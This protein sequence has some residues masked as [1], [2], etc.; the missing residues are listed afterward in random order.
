MNLE[1]TLANHALWLK[2]EGG[3]RANLW[4]TCLKGA[5]LSGASLQEANLWGANL[6]KVNLQEANLQGA[7]LQEANLQGA[8]LQEANL[9]EAN[10]RG[11]N[12]REANLRGANLLGT[13][14]DPANIPNMKGIDQFERVGDSY[15]GYRTRKSVFVGGTVYEDGESYTAPVFSTSETECHPG[16][17]LFPT[18]DALAEYMACND[19]IQYDP[20]RV[21]TSAVHGWDGKW[22]CREFT[23]IG[24]YNA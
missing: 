11:A 20:I 12:L 2:G 17:Y 15:I 22:R 21:M 16:L 10:L 19:F 3:E 9:R 18:Y 14:L 5:N 6:Y 24:G 13:C 4:G 8:N 7:N 1:K 23:V